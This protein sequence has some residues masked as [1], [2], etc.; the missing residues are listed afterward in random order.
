MIGAELP[1]ELSVRL[2]RFIAHEAR[3]LDERRHDEWLAL[4]APDGK[5][6]V[7]SHPDQT[8]MRLEPS[9]A[10][11]DVFLLGLRIA[12]LRH[13]QAHSQH[14]P[15]RALHVL[16]ASQCID[17]DGGRFVMRTPFHYFEQRGDDQV[18]LPGCATHE[19]VMIDGTL[20]IRL[21][22][23]DLL[24]AGRALPMIQLFP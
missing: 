15:S 23:V 8:E 1:D 2:T 17:A 12:R 6:W 21:K 5:Y 20:K 9:L 10:L 22:R 7:P 11:E 4:F 16:Q 19:L 14:P 13:P 18:S 24:A 3:L